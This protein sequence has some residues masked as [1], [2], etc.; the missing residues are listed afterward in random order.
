M[1]FVRND[2]ELKYRRNVQQVVARVSDIR[3]RSEFQLICVGWSYVWLCVGF[4]FPNQWREMDFDGRYRP[5]SQHLCISGWHYLEVFALT[6]RRRDGLEVRVP[7][8]W[9]SHEA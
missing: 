4:D 6:H 3:R 1:P 9:R 8:S 5:V 7:A 2:N